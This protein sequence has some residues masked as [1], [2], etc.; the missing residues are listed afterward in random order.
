MIF[1]RLLVWRDPV[2]RP[3]PENMA[4]DEWLLRT[5]TEPLLRI[6][7]WEGN[8]MSLGYF[9]GV[10]EA[11][12]CSRDEAVSLVRRATGG[13]V[14]DHRIDRTYSLVVPK[15]HAAA[16]LPGAGSYR[17]IHSALAEAMREAGIETR[18][19]ERD[20]DGESAACFEK[21]VAWDIVGAGGRKLAGAGQRRTRNG[22]LHQGSVITGGGPG[23]IFEVFAGRLAAEAETVRREPPEEELA[24]SLK[25]FEDKSW[26]ERR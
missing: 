22:L 18:L 23:R 19:I 16:R 17:V 1:D 10:R 14:V 26:L 7:D 20:L 6:Y 13:G 15:S 5:V 21:P 24:A 3:G 4:V 11:E 25:R 8:W 12:R 9:T 2:P